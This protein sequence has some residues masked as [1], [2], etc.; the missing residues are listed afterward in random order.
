MPEVA[1][2]YQLLEG[3][4]GQPADAAGPAAA[5]APAPHAAGMPSGSS[6]A[7]QPP[8]GDWTP[9]AMQLARQVETL[10]CQLVTVQ[11]ALKYEQ[12]QHRGT[13]ERL[14]AATSH[15]AALPAGAI[16]GCSREDAAGGVSELNLGLG[17]GVAQ[18]SRQEAQARR[19]ATQVQP[20]AV[21]APAW[22]AIPGCRPSRGVCP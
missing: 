6:A 20:A 12:Q 18:A 11:Q 16:G 5:A 3:Q 7:A 1:G 14:A 9:H 17:L 4:Q 15:L 8:P 21:R 10:T 13:Q 2:L 19:A 22:G